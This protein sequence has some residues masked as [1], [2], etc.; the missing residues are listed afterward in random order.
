MITL[1]RRQTDFGD[2]RVVACRRTGSIFYYHG[3]ICQSEAD[4][5]GVS[6]APYIH[7]IYDLLLQH[8]AQHILMIGCGGGTLGTMLARSGRS[9]VIV[10]NDPHAIMVAKRYFALPFE[11]TCH[12]ADGRTF[13]EQNETQF[14]AVVID[15]FIGDRIPEHLCS[16]DFFR[17]I[18]ESLRK[19]GSVFLNCLTAHDLDFRADHLAHALCLSGFRARI[20]STQGR[21]EQNSV[22]IGG[23]IDELR[24]PSIHLTPEVEADELMQDLKRMTFREARRPR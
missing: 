4:R 6:L 1:A 22:V 10:D 18:R 19:S 5:N 8:E 2:T 11:V 13:L 23:A 17:L 21:V 15:A 20:L 3:H 14:D 7:A 12:I 24:L 9:V 16:R